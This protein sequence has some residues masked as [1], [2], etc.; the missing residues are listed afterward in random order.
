VSLTVC[1]IFA[2]AAY[3]I[4]T[5]CA[6]LP[7][8]QR[9]R[10]SSAFCWL[11]NL[12][13]GVGAV[14]IGFHLFKADRSSDAEPSYSLTLSAPRS[15]HTPDLGGQ[16]KAILLPRLAESAPSVTTRPRSAPSQG[17]LALWV[18]SLR[19]CDVLDQIVISIKTISTPV[20]DSPH[21]FRL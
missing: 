1:W 15:I 17:R 3:T 13:G 7:L 10:R 6:G 19:D 9:I 2:V 20:R 11:T 4:S 14:E 5:R 21:P 16:F 12:S 8:S 18:Q